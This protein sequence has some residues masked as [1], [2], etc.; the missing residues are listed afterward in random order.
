MTV[1]EMKELKSIRHCEKT[2]GEKAIH[3]MKKFKGV[4][5]WQ[6]FKGL[7]AARLFRALQ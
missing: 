3:F 6:S 5:S 4:F 2:P 7:Q 1:T